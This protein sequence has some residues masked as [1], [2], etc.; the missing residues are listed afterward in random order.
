MNKIYK[1]TIVSILVLAFFLILAVGSTGNDKPSSQNSTS[2]T[3]QHQS[4][5]QSSTTQQQPIKDEMAWTL[6]VI[7]S[8]NRNIAHDD[9]LV[10]QFANH[11][12]NIDKKTVQS[13]T[14]IGDI[15]AKAWEIIRREI[16][17]SEDILFLIGDLDNAVPDDME[18]KMD[19]VEVAALYIVLRQEE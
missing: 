18:A 14:E 9:P 6:A 13:R 8:G 15:T 1:K 7:K 19:F 10:S 5:Q 4:T 2:T 16:N 12:D 17:P 11:L 3:S